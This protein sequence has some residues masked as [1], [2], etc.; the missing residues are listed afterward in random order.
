[1]VILNHY[2]KYLIRKYDFEKA[3]I[4]DIDKCKNVIVSSNI[5]NKNIRKNHIKTI[6]N[7]ISLP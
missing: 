2:Q 5:I 7:K 1:M 4:V 3:S 6:K